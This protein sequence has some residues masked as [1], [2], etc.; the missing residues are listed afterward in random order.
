MHNMSVLAGYARRRQLAH[1]DQGMQTA[2]KVS[3]EASEFVHRHRFELF[4][5]ALLESFQGN[6]KATSHTLNFT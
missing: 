4:E 2:L 5:T 3:L 6:L 1:H